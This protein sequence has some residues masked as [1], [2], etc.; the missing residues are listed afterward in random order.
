[1]NTLI[2]RVHC[3]WVVTYNNHFVNLDYTSPWQIH[4]YLFT[5]LLLFTKC[6]CLLD[7]F[8][9][10]TVY[11]QESQDINPLLFSIHWRIVLWK[12]N[13]EPE[14]R[15]DPC[16]VKGWVGVRR[17]GWGGGGVGQRGKGRK[18]LH[19]VAISETELTVMYFNLVRSSMF[20]IIFTYLTLW[21]GPRMVLP[22]AVPW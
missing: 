10:C 7:Y 1:M 2:Y 15:E 17:Q 21:V 3:T 20:W 8:N 5:W 6:A 14:M 22:R 19:V 16:L 18:L 11:P 13:F 4:C 9:T 12:E